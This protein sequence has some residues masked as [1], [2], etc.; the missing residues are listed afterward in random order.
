MQD[1]TR[2]WEFY[3]VRY[4]IGTMTG[5]LLVNQVPRISPQLGEILF[6]GIP[7]GEDPLARATLL[8]GYGLLFCYIASVPILVAHAARFTM[9]RVSDFFPASKREKFSAYFSC[10]ADV[11]AIVLVG[12][13]GLVL[14]VSFLFFGKN[15]KEQ[16]FLINWTIYVIIFILWVEWAILARLIV[17]LDL[18]YQG[19]RKLAS[20]RAEKQK[21]DGGFIDSYRHLREHGNSI[22]IVILEL[23][24]G[25][26]LLGMLYV[27]EADASVLDK[28][29]TYAAWAMPLLFFW[30]APGAAIWRVAIA[31][32]RRFSDVDGS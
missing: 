2:W 21:E 29:N 24:L 22:C 27:I 14:A 20:A 26:A 1:N 10:A 8:L 23:V 19:M 9:P 3:F 28:M 18:A 32:E 11:V 6:F 7:V 30:M 4:A 16:T 17:R 25:G 12:I 5:A 13:W 31:F 15:L